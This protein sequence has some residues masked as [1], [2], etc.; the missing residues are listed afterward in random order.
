MSVPEHYLVI[1]EKEKLTTSQIAHSKVKELEEKY[2]GIS[3]Q[4]EVERLLASAGKSL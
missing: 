1:E 4:T 2:L 3:G